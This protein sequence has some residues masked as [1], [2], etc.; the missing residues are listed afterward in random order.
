MKRFLIGLCAGAGVFLSSVSAAWASS[1]S[2]PNYNLRTITIGGYN[3]QVHGIAALDGSH[4][5]EFMPIYYLQ[6]GLDQLGY[7]ATWNGTKHTLQIS[8][9]TGAAPNLSSVAANSAGTVIDIDGVAVTNAPKALV[10]VDPA[11]GGATSFLPIFYIAQAIEQLG[12]QSSY[13][14]AKGTWDVQPT[15]SP[16]QA[17]STS[18]GSGSTSN[19]STDGNSTPG[20]TSQAFAASGVTPGDVTNGSASEVWYNNGN[21]VNLQ[22]L[23][24]NQKSNLIPIVGQ[25]VGSST[26]DVVVEVY[27]G[28]EENW[29]Y[30]VPVQ[31][32]GSFS[33]TIEDPWQGSASIDVGFPD[34]PNP[35]D[36]F[37]L[38]INNASFESFNNPL[39]SLS[40]EQMSLLES[41]MVNYTED[42]QIYTLA[43]QITAGDATT[44]AKIQAVHDWVAAHIE[45]NFPADNSN[46]VPWQQATDTLATDIGV[47]Q[48]EAAVAAALLRSLGVP[49]ETINGT[50]YYPDGQIAGPHQ[51]NAAWD[52]AQWVTF[53]ATWDQVYYQGVQVQLPV[54]IDET[55][56]NPNP[57]TFA[58]THKPST[59]Q[60]FD[61]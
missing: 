48:D 27:A 60:W 20:Y 2:Q 46:T 35:S 33:A 58:L 39:P 51:W 45:Y 54:G 42:Y 47:C 52:G 53:D 28:P 56:F 17:N 38:N 8:T 10:A 30:S 1:G 43:Q 55:Y 21:Q 11:T 40:T 57:V 61:W 5:T 50:A 31:S 14:G 34:L 23:T 22:D 29:F 49:T 7:T 18:T 16:T 19:S 12:L 26:A 4:P 3:A 15:A 41:W 59:G 24:Y 37:G 6:Q 44:D 9:P 13:N 36:T 32:D 25:V